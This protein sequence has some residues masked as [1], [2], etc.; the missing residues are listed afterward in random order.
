M[1]QAVEAIRVRT[2]FIS[3]L[4]LGTKGCQADHILNFLRS[5]D[6]DTIY[7]VGDIVDGWRLKSGWYW[8]QAHNDVMQKLL[9]KVRNGARLVYIPGNHDE[10]LRDYLGISLGGIELADY[11]LH[12]AA[13]GRTYLV[14]HGD[15]FDLVVRHARWLALLG[16]GAYTAALFLN[17]Y[18]NVARRKL[19]FTYW[20]LSSWA[21]ARVKNAV[22]Y[23]GR[24]EELLA[25]EA[26]R[27]GAHGVICGHIHHPVMRDLDGIAY[28]NT[29][30]WVES[31]TGI[32][33]HYDGVLELVRWTEPGAG[34]PS[35]T[36]V[37]AD[38]VAR[39]AA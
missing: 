37:L 27:H 25:A 1:R 21:K 7:L 10:F 36:K 19:G 9:R 15:Q 23:I 34:L 5:Y 18:L 8:P 13:D 17:T 39:E 6:A 24:F 12:K 14:T 30:D 35:E 3:D 11:A 32:V 31:C 26:K 33:E 38:L 20:S 22:N 2:L 4:H 28:V 16:D 29:G